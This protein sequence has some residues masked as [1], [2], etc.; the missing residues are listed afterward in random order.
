MTIGEPQDIGGS[1]SVDSDL[2]DWEEGED[3]EIVE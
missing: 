3:Q 1:D 2:E